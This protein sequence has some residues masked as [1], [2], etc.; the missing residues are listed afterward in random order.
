MKLNPLWKSPTTGLDLVFYLS[1]MGCTF[2]DSRGVNGACNT[3][4]VFVFVLKTLVCVGTGEIVH[5]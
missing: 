2:T 4:L 3:R 5:L 1:T